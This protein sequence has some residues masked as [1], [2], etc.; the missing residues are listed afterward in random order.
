MPSVIGFVTV[1]TNMAPQLVAPDA[2]AG[3]ISWPCGTPPWC[4]ADSLAITLLD[5]LSG[6]DEIKLCTGYKAASGEIV[7][8]FP[9][10]ARL[11]EGCT[12]VYESHAGWAEEIDQCRSISELPPACQSYLQSLQTHLGVPIEFVSVGPDRRQ[13]IAAL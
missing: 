9:P 2:V 7:D 5:V 11:L 3:S 13:T 12:P 8:R 1:A 6:F 10:D 4:A